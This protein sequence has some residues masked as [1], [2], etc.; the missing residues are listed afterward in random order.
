MPASKNI[1]RNP[2]LLPLDVLSGEWAVELS[3]AAFL[4]DPNGEIT[5]QVAC[6]WIENGAFLVIRMPLD[7]PDSLWLIS[8]DDS[9]KDY[10]V[11]YFDSR[12]VSRIYQMSFHDNSWKMWRNSPKFSQ[13]FEGILS[14]DG[15]SITARWEKSTDG[16]TWKHDF[17]LRYRR[18]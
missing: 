11:L 6:E 3:E 12:K 7:P 17:T 14:G 8:R 5:M 10:T 15:N 18:A 2:A 1:V 4:P 13:R 9:S 16:E